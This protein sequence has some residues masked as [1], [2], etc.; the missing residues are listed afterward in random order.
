[1]T[2]ITRT[3]Q[4]TI[5]LRKQARD[6][7]AHG[8]LPITRPKDTW[9][10]RGSGAR[11]ALCGMKIDFSEAEIEAEF[12]G[13]HG[14]SRLEKLH[15]HGYCFVEFEFERDRLRAPSRLARN[16]AGGELPAIGD[17]LTSAKST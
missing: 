1:M 11:C 12:A 5:Q 15:F 4:R 10:G 6:L 2:S 3:E 9:G 16:R 14:A 17:P 13:A 8:R 7:I